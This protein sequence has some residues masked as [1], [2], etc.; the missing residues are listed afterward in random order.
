MNTDPPEDTPAPSSSTT[1]SGPGS[2]AVGRDVRDS[3]IITGDSN[4]I[5]IG[6]RLVRRQIPWRRV[7][8]VVV[9]V[10]AIAVAAFVLYPRPVPTMSGDLNVAVAEFG[11]LDARGA[12]V[13]SAEART[14]ADSLYNTLSGELQ[15]INQASASSEH[16]FDIQVWGPAQV[17]RVD[18][19]APE[20]RAADAEQIATRGKAHLL[21]YGYVQSDQR[22]NGFVFVPQFYLRNLQDTPEL[23]GQHDLGRSVTVRSLD[24]PDSRQTLREDLKGRTRSFAEFVIGLSQFANDKF[25]DARSH[26][27][28][29]DAD[30]QW[31]ENS[32]GKEVLYLF[33]GVTAGKLDDLVAARA[34]FEHALAINPEFARAYAGLA[35][36]QF[37]ESIGKPNAC[38]R[39]TINVSGMQSAIA[40]YQRALAAKVQPARS[41][42]ASWTALGLGRAYLCLSQAD[43]GNYWS[44]AE[45]ELR[46][47]IADYD[48]G[49]ESARDFAAEAH[50][51][52][53]FVLLPGRCDPDRDAKYRAAAQEYQ[54]AID[55]SAFH[56]TRQGF[57]YEMLGFIDGQL[58][59]VDQAKAAYR[60]AMRVDPDNRDRY[61]Q[62]GQNAPP[63]LE[64]CP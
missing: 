51:N 25:G 56:P 18:G 5:I 28:K 3:T 11:A 2:V 54:R 34:Y 58:G 35:A 42:V 27:E 19:I 38:T 37:Q 1:A 53:G 6:P 63:P 33:L 47:V 13:Q 10:A 20:A 23:Q 12:A 26:F 46:L 24:D 49:N 31:D 61:Q 40:G 30:R 15:T 48:A 45:R 39:A 21:V 9:P 14:L 36:V 16:H 22:S 4:T 64:T 59:A 29:A 62:L 60:D 57:Y 44:D 32:G 55:L 17:G 7:L 50:S 52:L 41:N 8:L 43:A